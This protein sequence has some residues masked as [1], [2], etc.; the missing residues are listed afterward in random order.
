M[1]VS[2][3]PFGLPSP[4]QASQ[5]A[6]ASMSPLLPWVTSRK[7][8]EFA[9]SCGFKNPAGLALMPCLAVD[10]RRSPA[11]PLRLGHEQ[12]PTR[13]PTVHQD[14]EITHGGHD[15]SRLPTPYIRCVA[16]QGWNDGAADNRHAND[17]GPLG[18]ACPQ[19]LARQRKNR[20]KHN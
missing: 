6:A 3:P 5:P 9:Y 18:R 2:A 14:A 20:G 13:H 17:P 7:A 12:R 8:L 16:G 10:D 11:D 19:T 1:P 15:E 4:V